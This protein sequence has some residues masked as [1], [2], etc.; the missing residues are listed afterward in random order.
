[1]ATLIAFLAF[2]VLLAVISL[3]SLAADSRSYSRLRT[4]VE[5]QHLRPRVG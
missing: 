5:V 3:T 2:F 1:M 4:D